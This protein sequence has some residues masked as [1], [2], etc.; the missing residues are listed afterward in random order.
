MRVVV[1]LDEIN[2]M[3]RLSFRQNFVGK[4]NLTGTDTK[5]DYKFIINFTTKPRIWEGNTRPT[6]AIFQMK[7]GSGVI[8]S[9]IELFKKSMPNLAWENVLPVHVTG[10]SADVLK[11]KTVPSQTPF[12][13]K[14]QTHTKRHNL[15]K[16]SGD[17]I[18]SVGVQFKLVADCR[19]IGAFARCKQ[20]TPL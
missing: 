3:Y 16:F 5:R 2:R 11:V 20:D 18:E 4:G 14:Y 17:I 9:L 19:T 1:L 10:E 7:D 8:A 6:E 12:E 15:Y 13:I